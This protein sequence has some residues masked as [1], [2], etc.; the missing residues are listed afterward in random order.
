M[1]TDTAHLQMDSTTCY[2]KECLVTALTA[3][4]AAQHPRS[5]APAQPP[6]AAALAAA[7]SPQW[8]AKQHVIAYGSINVQEAP[9]LSM[10][11]KY[12]SGVEAI[13]WAV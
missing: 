5:Q 12:Y 7:A 11:T 10:M 4:P 13:V 8:P 1:A 6:S 9:E 3:P 2:T